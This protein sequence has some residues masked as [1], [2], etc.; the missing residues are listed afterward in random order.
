M[1]CSTRT[2]LS[3][4]K[5][6][7][8]AQEAEE[9]VASKCAPK[10]KHLNECLTKEVAI[11]IAPFSDFLYGVPTGD[12]RLHKLS[13]HYMGADPPILVMGQLPWPVGKA[14]P[15]NQDWF[16]VCDVRRDV[17]LR[18]ESEICYH[19]FSF[20]DISFLILLL[21]LPILVS[22]WVLTGYWMFCGGQGF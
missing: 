17:A 19:Q 18:M 11:E 21:L 3:T 20:L 12:S 7:K 14:Q 5:A 13:S 8:T 4:D 15:V 1:L 6:L 2:T 16:D 22:I 9:H 10:R